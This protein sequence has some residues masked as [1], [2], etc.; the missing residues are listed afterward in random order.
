MIQI[1]QL[2]LP[3]GTDGGAASLEHPHLEGK[4]RKL[5]RLRTGDPF[6]Y[7]I[8]RHSIDA[9]KKPELYDI[10]SVLVELDGNEKHEK[11]LIE[12]LRDRNILYKKVVSYTFPETNEDAKPMAHRPVI[13]GEGPAGLFC[14]LELARAGYKP[15]ILERGKSIEER[16]KDVEHFWATG[17]LNPQSNIQFGEGG[18]G[19]YSDGKLNSNVKDQAG[20]TDEVLNT[21]IDA[22]AHPD[23]AYEFHP[24]VG[25]DVLRDV[26]VNLRN[27]ME[28]L[29]GEV[30]FET[31]VTDLVI[32][33][34]EI[35]GVKTRPSNSD[36]SEE[37]IPAEHVV[38]AI[39]HSARDTFRTLHAMEIP[40]EQKNFALGFRVSHLQSLIN[41]RQ[42]GVSD[43]EEMERL[44]LGAS[45]YKLT[46][47]TKSG[48]GVYSFCM[49]PGGYVV[50]ASS[51]PGRLAVNGMSNQKRD[52]KRANSAI[53]V[54]V[55]AEDFGGTDVL[56][57]LRFQ[58]ALEEKAYTIGNGKIPV[59]SYPDYKT[60]IENTGEILY[61]AEKCGAS[62]PSEELCIKGQAVYAPLHELLP[63]DI[64]EM[65]VEGMSY[66]ERVIPGYAG[67][68]AYV[69]GLESRTSSPVRIPRGETFE[70][71]GVK[72]L[73]PCGEGA[74]YAGG[75]M[76]AAIDG[77]KVA[78]AIGQRNLPAAK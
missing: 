29:G 66:F 6:T 15:L 74:G 33:N 58:E 16:T 50:N 49:C 10:Y 37:F 77:I 68:D 59:E 52:S 56:D 4:I 42:Y 78:E 43:P 34:G 67:E 19:T 38:L 70:S 71:I 8:I 12:K 21:F 25:T 73:Y 51:E 48:R 18:A 30:R 61:N 65:F 27:E 35:K 5:L 64:S 3:C 22:G 23:I 9:R 57:G 72:G 11:Q 44:H 63:K 40:M 75:I 24:H 13:I 45:S 1:N 32:E 2:K 55:G 28:Q 39:G 62:A 69:I 41:G 20:R 36:A 31:T 17:D 7:R 14:G 26:V 76:S 53:V 46:Y 54:T 60:A 47:Q